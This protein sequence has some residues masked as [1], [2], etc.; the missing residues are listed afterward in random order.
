MPKGI[1]LF[2]EYFLFLSLKYYERLQGEK[3]RN[4]IVPKE[5]QKNRLLL[6]IP[7]S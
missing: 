6:P 1:F 7:A 2:F 3:I 5:K 4:F